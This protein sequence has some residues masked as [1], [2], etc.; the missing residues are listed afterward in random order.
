MSRPRRRRRSTQAGFTLIELMISLVLFS[1]AIAGVLAVAVAMASGFR[2]QK[3]TIGAESAARSAMEFLADAIRGASPGVPSGKI[4]SLDSAACP[5]ETLD[6]TNDTAGPDELTVVFAYGSLVTSTTAVFANGTTALDI[7]DST[8]FSDGDMVVVT[9]H[10]TGHLAK[11]GTV[12]TNKLNF[13]GFPCT[14]GFT[15]PAGAVV[16]RATRARFFVQP[17]D[18]IPTLWMDPDADGTSSPQAAEPLAEGIEDMQVMIGID[19]NADGLITET[20]DGQLD[21]YFF[22]DP[23]TEEVRPLPSVPRSIKLALVARVAKERMGNATFA[24]PLVG[25]HAPA[26][27]DKWRR[28]A[29][30]SVI[31]IRN[32]QDSK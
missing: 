26:G 17:L 15:Y 5:D 7:V 23:L 6:I 29:L 32:I 31:E 25:D 9:D 16:I 30:D 10:K 27:F 11:I 22:N 20:A 12:G 3:L 13:A 2:E 28:R 8:G 21:E 24:A 19:T 14:A 4:I 1:F 18:G